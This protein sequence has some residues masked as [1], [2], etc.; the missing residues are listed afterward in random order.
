VPWTA[1]E[2]ASFNAMLAYKML[3]ISQAHGS[4]A[5]SQQYSYWGWDS[6]QDS[7]LCRRINSVL[8]THPTDQNMGLLSDDQTGV[9][10]WVYVMFGSEMG[11]GQ[12]TTLGPQQLAVPGIYGSQAA[13]LNSSAG[14]SGKLPSLLQWSTGGADVLQFC[15]RGYYPPFGA[16]YINPGWSNGMMANPDGSGGWRDGCYGAACLSYGCG[17]TGGLAWNMEGP[18]RFWCWGMPYAKLK[19]TESTPAGMTRAEV[20]QNVLSWLDGTL[21]LALPGEDRWQPYAGA[22][23]I[24]SVTP[25]YWTTSPSGYIT[26][27]PS[28][29][30]V[31]YPDP[32]GT[33]AYRTSYFNQPGQRYIS[34]S[35][36]GNTGLDCADLDFQFPWYA[37]ITTNLG[38][39]ETVE[40]TAAVPPALPTDDTV[41]FKGL[42]VEDPDQS[43]T[44]YALA[45][46]QLPSV[47]LNY[48]TPVPVVA[49]YYASV[50]GD[51]GDE[52]YATYGATAPALSWDNRYKLECEAVAHW[53]DTLLYGARP[54]ALY[55]SMFPGHRMFVPGTGNL[56]T[57]NVDGWYAFRRIFDIDPTQSPAGRAGSSWNEARFGFTSLLAQGRVVAFDYRSI[58]CWNPD[59]NYDL[60]ANTPADAV[61]DKFPVRCRLFTDYTTYVDSLGYPPGAQPYRWPDNQPPEASYVEGG[62]YLVDTGAP[63]FHFR[64][65]DDPAKPDPQDSV[66]GSSG[67]KQIV[68]SYILKY[69]VPPYR[70]WVEFDPLFNSIW[71]SQGSYVFPLET[72]ISAS[73]PHTS[74]LI[75]N[76]SDGLP[77]GSYWITLQGE[78]SGSPIAIDHYYYTNSQ[79][80]FAP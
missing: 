74:V 21:T 56:L 65:T 12:T 29:P 49:G 76:G 66:T 75:L 14:S 38:G 26:G 41:V 5:S 48:G 54:A 79:M 36:P 80:V 28:A 50:T 55:W 25:G 39:V 51:T 44:R 64:I 60:D 58:P 37:Y 31:D 30:G 22:P 70:T 24:L 4:V 42:L 15:T 45:S 27:Q 46:G 11:A 8:M 20:L 78:D 7:Q 3:L 16:T 62:C 1:Q 43:W 67:D 47:I 69:G 63:V 59:L 13:E 10:G 77:P 35:T 18:G 34:T 33:D 68:F 9:F 72:G 71:G 23:E 73:G 57:D 52:L 32:T 53:P 17:S 40:D 19:V 61:A 2:E 6:D